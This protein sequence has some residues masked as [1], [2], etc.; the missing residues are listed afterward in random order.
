MMRNQGVLPYGVEVTEKAEAV[1]ARSGLPL[2]V[3]T[4]RA[5]GLSRAMAEA[6]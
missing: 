5:L 6:V 4:M 3:E 2:V 1:T